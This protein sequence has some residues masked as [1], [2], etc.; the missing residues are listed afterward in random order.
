MAERMGAKT[1]TIRGDSVSEAVTSYAAKNH[2]TKIVVGRTQ[3]RWRKFL[4]LTAVDQIIR[5]S[6]DADVFVATGEEEPV[7]PDRAAAGRPAVNWRGY[8]QALLLMALATLLGRA[9]HSFFSPANIIMIYL[10]CVVVAAAFWGFGPS[11]LTCILSVLLWDYF[12]VKPHFTFAVEDTQY[13]FAFITLLLVSLTI[14]YLTTRIRQQTEAAQRRESE[15]ATLYGLSRTLASVVGLDS[16]IRAIIDSTRKTFDLDA[17]IFLPD[18][19]ERG[20]SGPTPTAR[21]SLS[22][23]MRPRPRPG[24]SS[25][26]KWWDTAPTRSRRPGHGTCRSAPPEVRSG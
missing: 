21:T 12:F 22:A 15:T 18:A 24:A 8:L 13:I 17:V 19:R 9:V 3:S 6:R 14:S 25:T 5:R 11:I 7:R 16:T 10:L 4:G 20:S 26:R 23:R 2:I 1:V